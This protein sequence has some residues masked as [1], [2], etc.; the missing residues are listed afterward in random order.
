[1]SRIDLATAD[2]DGAILEAEAGVGNDTR[3]AFFRKAAL[4]GGA[5]IGTAGMFSAML[6]DLADARPSK[7][8][9]LRILKYALTLEYLEAAFYKEAVSQGGLSGQQLELAKLFADHEAT[10]V[11]ALRQTI[12]SLGSKV[13]GSPKFDFRDTNKGG[14]FIETAF[15]LENLGVRAYLGQAPRILNRKILAAAASIATIE[16]R[17]AAAVAVVIGD[18]PFNVGDKSITPSGAFDRRSSMKK[19]RSE[20]AATNYIQG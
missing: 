7:R 6:P 11:T 14:N 4:T 3:A 5:A 2:V 17:H 1:M 10:H 19:I 9:D 8:Q 13:P 18:S 12:R 15:V 20:V 16:A